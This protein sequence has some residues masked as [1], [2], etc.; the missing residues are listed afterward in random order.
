MVSVRDLGHLRSRH[1]DDSLALLEHLG[2]ADSLLDVGSGGGFP[3]IPLALANPDVSTTLV[4][5]NQKKC[6]F[7]R[8]VV[9]TLKLG[10]VDVINAD[11]R[12]IGKELNPFDAISARAVASPDQVW[13]W[14]RGLLSENGRLLLQT[15][16]VFEK[17]LPN[18][19][20]ESHRS[21]GIGWINV[22]RRERI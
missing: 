18:A 6:S 14:C 1:L 12:D 17:A 13:A 19:V 16:E 21:N 3:G 11:V 7:L 5:R 10:N 20:I 9:M 4:E 22:V 2:C 15:T 8:H